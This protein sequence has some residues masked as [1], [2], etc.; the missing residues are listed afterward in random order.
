MEKSIILET[1]NLTKIYS[2]RRKFFNFFGPQVSFMAVNNVSF[3]LH[4][5]EILGVL[6]PNGAGKTTIIQML[7]ST[8]TPSSGKI[9]YFDKDF[10]KHRSAILEN[11]AFA[12]T[13]LKLPARLTVL[14]NLHVY[15]KL[16][17]L[18]ATQIFERAEKFLKFFAM[19]NHKDKEISQLSAGQITR[20]MIV[21]AFLAY[22]KIV[23]LDEPTAALDPNI[24]KDVRKFLLEQ[25]EEYGVSILLTSHNMDEVSQVC[26][27]VLVLKEGK[28]IASDTP[29]SLAESVSTSRVHLMI[30][31]DENCAK[32]MKFAQENNLPIK[33]DGNY[34]E[35]SVNEQKIAELLIKV[36]LA[37]IQYTQIYI[38]TPT[39]ED[40]FLQLVKKS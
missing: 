12:S 3:Q 31:C 2:P 39:L 20:V 9:F 25:R 17:G 26:N 28:I 37:G 24:A 29:E 10:S 33:Q 13:Y 35:I 7:L 23:L 5:G 18:S 40:Y 8:L 4:K 14:E 1:Q 11:V 15:G 27:R 19:W 32:L 34:F 22:P 36:A 38:D 6:G 30:P 16:F 21:K